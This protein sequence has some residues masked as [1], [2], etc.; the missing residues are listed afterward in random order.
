MNYDASES[1]HK[2]EKNTALAIAEMV[3]EFEVATGLR[4]SSIEI[5]IIDASTAMERRSVIGA[6]RIGVGSRK[7]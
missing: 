4:V 5:P 7:W 1:I 3:K 6:V 2:L